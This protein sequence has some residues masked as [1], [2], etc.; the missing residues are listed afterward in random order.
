M[1]NL[2]CEYLKEG[3]VEGTDFPQLL[4]LWF[5]PQLGT[6]VGVYLPTMQNIF[7][8]LLFL[9]LAWIVGTAGV[10]QAFAIVLLCCS[11]VSNSRSYL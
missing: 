1:V 11:C 8:V 7:G 10:F 9:R 3:S 4:N 2:S 5:Q 6:V